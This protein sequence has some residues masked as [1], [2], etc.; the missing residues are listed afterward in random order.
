MER[1]VDSLY[2]YNAGGREEGLEDHKPH[3]LQNMTRRKLPRLFLHQQRAQGGEGI[4]PRG[5]ASFRNCS[6]NP[7]F[8]QAVGD[9]KQMAIESKSEISLVR[10][11]VNRTNRERWMAW[12]CYSCRNCTEGRNVEGL[13]GCWSWGGNYLVLIQPL[14]F[15]SW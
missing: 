7:A 4:C 5:N 3:V 14:T 2:L 15:P 13:G 6:P 11:G 12:D 1:H 9:R 8:G 10:Q